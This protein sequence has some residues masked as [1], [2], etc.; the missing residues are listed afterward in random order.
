MDD[1][2]GTELQS[3]TYNGTAAQLWAI[4]RPGTGVRSGMAQ[5]SGLLVPR[6]GYQGCPASDGIRAGW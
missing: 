5:R 2:G 3:Y 4:P 6:L 1:T